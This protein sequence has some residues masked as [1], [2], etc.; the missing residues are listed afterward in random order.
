L[1]LSAFHLINPFEKDVKQHKVN[2]ST[3]KYGLN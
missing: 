2:T 3:L 1:D